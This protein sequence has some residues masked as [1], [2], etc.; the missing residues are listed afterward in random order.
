MN[1]E[2]K[3]R[4]WADNKFYNKCLV[5]NTNNT[6]DEKWTC[7]M[8]WL[9]KQK[10]WVHC[11]NG[12]ICQY[13]GLKDKNGKEIYEG[14]VVLLTCYNYE[15]PVFGGKFKVIYDDING[16]WLLVDLENKDRGFAFGEIRSYYKAEFEVIGNVFEKG[17]LLNDSEKS[18]KN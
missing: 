10:E 5:G 2:I 1:R 11:D 4:I 14:D 16:M 17:I 6:N 3:F 9:E 18:K 13:T 8:V 7:P 12:I 15:E